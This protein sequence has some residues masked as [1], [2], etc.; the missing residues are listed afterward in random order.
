MLKKLLVDDNEELT[1]E[2]KE[3]VDKGNYDS[4]SFE[5]EEPEEDDYYYEDDKE[6]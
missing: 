2:Q 6:E 5:E 1:K 4:F 3:E